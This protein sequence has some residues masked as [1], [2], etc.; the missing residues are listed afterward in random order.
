MVL[1]LALAAGC[2][3]A[4]PPVP[5]LPLEQ[6]TEPALEARGAPA[7]APPPATRMVSHMVNGQVF[8]EMVPVEAPA[9]DV[10]AGAAMPSVAAPTEQASA[11]QS[12]A[13]TCEAACAALNDALAGTIVHRVVSAANQV[14]RG[15]SPAEPGR[16]A[17][18]KRLEERAGAVEPAA[19]RS[20]YAAAVR[21]EPTVRR[22][23]LLGRAADE[24]NDG[25]GAL[26]AVRRAV[27]LAPGD[28]TAARELAA[29]ERRHAVEQRFDTIAQEHFVARFEGE[30]KKELA[31]DA[32]RVLDE[33]WRS[34]GGAVDL[35]PTAPITVVFYTG[36]AY[37][38]ATGAREWS[39]GQ[40]DG[41]IR[42]RAGSLKQGQ[43]A[44]RDLLFHE[45]LHAAIA[46]SVAADVPAWLH[47]GLAQ[48]LEPGLDRARDL[49]PLEGRTRAE[50]PSLGELSHGFSRLTDRGQVRLYYA[51]AL[52]IVD[53]LARWRGERSFAQLFA[54]IR[55]GQRF[56]AALDGVY[57]LDERLLQERWQSRY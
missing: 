41:K 28:A 42:L 55:G 36:A 15:C 21:L 31:W 30:A 25:P 49:A 44:L 13:E 8:I 3:R 5:A 19:R 29:L 12:S 16:K 17:L 54:A 45:Y 6:P 53:E 26:D 57:G 35:H 7:P 56:E 14:E 38:E 50:L 51:C 33:A 1:V 9:P 34:V 24:E 4:P 37:Q 43:A 52:D 40:F 10:G 47:E 46:T 27:A 18:A 23:L 22:L 11:E 32:L 2:T 20:H 39:G 48:R